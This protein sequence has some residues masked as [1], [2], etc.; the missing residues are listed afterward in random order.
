MKLSKVNIIA[1]IAT[2]AILLGIVV[3]FAVFANPKGATGAY[4]AVVHDGDG[5]EYVLPLDEDAVLPV[6]SSLGFNA[7]E[8]ADGTVF[9]RGADCDTLDCVHQGALDSPGPQIICLPHKLW[10][11]VVASGARDESASMDV[12]AVQGDTGYDTLAR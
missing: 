2:A 9:V 3:A 10:I 6:Q 7:V 1:L 8:I 11:E 12:S 5:N 4:E